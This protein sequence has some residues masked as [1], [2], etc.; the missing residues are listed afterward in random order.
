MKR[1]TELITRSAGRLAEGE[2]KFEE[3]K[4]PSWLW[5]LKK[6]STILVKRAITFWLKIRIKKY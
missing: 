2:E 3:T 4:D 5:F 6:E 1:L